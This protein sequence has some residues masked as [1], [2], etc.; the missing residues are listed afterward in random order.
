MKSKFALYVSSILA[1]L[2]FSSVANATLLKF[3]GTEVNALDLNGVSASFEEFYNY[4]ISSAHTG[5]EVVDAVV[6]FLAELNGEYALYTIANKYRSGGANGKLDIA[7][8]A[9]SGSVLFVDDPKEDFGGTAFSFA[10]GGNLT[11]GLIFSGFAPDFSLSAQMSSRQTVQGA[12]FVDFAD[13]T[14]DSQSYTDLLP[15][16]GQFDITGGS[17][18]RAIPEPSI[19]MLMGLGLFAAMRRR[20]R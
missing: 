15:L 19:L 2:V 10:W 9:T 3:N 20:A 4:N 13:G 8:N 7:L 11:D 18:A 17:F 6:M 16:S 5:L 12:Y 1:A 14:F